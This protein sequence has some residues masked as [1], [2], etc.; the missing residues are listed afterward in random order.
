VVYTKSQYSK[1]NHTSL[2]SGFPIL[3]KLKFGDV[4]FAE[5]GNPE[6]L[7]NNSWRGLHRAGIEPRRALPH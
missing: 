7:E 4:D 3:F 2:S 5:G 1:R 6:I